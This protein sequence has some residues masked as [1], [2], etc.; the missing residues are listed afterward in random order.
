[1][2]YYS[3]MKKNDTM[4]FAA[5]WMDLKS[6]ILS[7]VNSDRDKYHMTSFRCG[8]KKNY[9]NEQYLQNRKRLTDIENKLMVTEGGSVEEGDKL[10]EWD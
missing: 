2:G 1:M 6:I 4:P 3:D 5:R 7:E 9:T 8:I 10:G